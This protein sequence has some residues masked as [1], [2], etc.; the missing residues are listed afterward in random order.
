MHMC[1]CSIRVK[2]F[3]PSGALNCAHVSRISGSPVA[4]GKAL[5]I[6]SSRLT[7]LKCQANLKTL[8]GNKP[9]DLF[10]KKPPSDISVITLLH[11]VRS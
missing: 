1:L 10:Q 9:S 2:S 11:K 7:R 6:Y 4:M 5:V 3:T 8:I